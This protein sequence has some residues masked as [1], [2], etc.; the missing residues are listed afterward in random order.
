MQNPWPS[1]NTWSS[2]YILDTDVALVDSHN[3]YCRSG[4]QIIKESF[5]QPYIGNPDKAK[6]VFL[7]LNPGHCDLDTKDH[8]ENN[9]FIKSMR[10]NLLHELTKRPFYPLDPRFINTGAGQW[11]WKRT[12]DLRNEG[13]DNDILAEKLMVIE[14]FPYHSRRFAKPSQ[15]LS[16][17]RYSFHLAK[18]MIGKKL[19]VRMRSRKEWTEVHPEFGT[20]PSLTNPRCGHVSKGNTTKE[21]FALII[22]ELKSS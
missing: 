4:T 5:P 1:S 9:E 8:S 13:I 2:P 22:A 11:W 17:Q 3:R 6:V 19:V 18:Q 15:L 14:W 12:K 16:S 21:L 20:A 10:L 7:A